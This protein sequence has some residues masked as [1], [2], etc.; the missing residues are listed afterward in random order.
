MREENDNPTSNFVRVF[1]CFV[2]TVRDFTLQ[3][4]AGEKALSEDEYLDDIL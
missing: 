1:P 4:R 2:W 3:L